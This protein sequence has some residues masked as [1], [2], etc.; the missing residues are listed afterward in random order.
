MALGTALEGDAFIFTSIFLA[1]HG[2]LNPFITLA[3]LYGST[4]AMDTF[5]Y[6][7]GARYAN[8]SAWIFRTVYKTSPYIDRHLSKRLAKTLFLTKFMY[9]VHHLALLRAGAL[10]IDPKRFL[11]YDLAASAV[12]IA[13]VGGFALLA[14]A[15]VPFLRHSLHFTEVVLTI[16]LALFFVVEFVI[17]QVARRALPLEPK[18]PAEPASATPQAGVEK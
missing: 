8:S 5:L 3:I 18:K 17:R 10:K 11:R 13:V 1:A 4:I 14:N 9:G 15:A 16:G 7:L 6:R 2:L 12:W